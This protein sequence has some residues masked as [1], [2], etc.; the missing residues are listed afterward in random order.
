[1]YRQEKLPGVFLSTIIDTL[2]RSTLLNIA[3]ELRTFLQE[4]SKLDG[5]G[6]RL[7]LIGRPGCFDHGILERYDRRIRG[8]GCMEGIKATEDFVRF[9]DDYTPYGPS[10][11]QRDKWIKDFQFRLP[12]IFSH[13]DLQP[14]NIFVNEGHVFGII[15]WEC[16]GWYPYF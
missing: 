13:G 10:R 5:E 3:S 14:E 6:I 12:T 7:G 1:L 16:A 8:R 9:I 2:D 11:E 15:D 4:L